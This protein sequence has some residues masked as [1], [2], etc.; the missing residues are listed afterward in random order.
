MAKNVTVTLGTPIPGHKGPIDKVVIREPRAGDYFELGEPVIY[1]QSREGRLIGAE[2]TETVKAYLDRLIV[3]PKD[4]LVLG[5]MDLA[6]SMKVKAAMMD[7]FIN[8][9]LKSFG[10]DAISSS[11]TSESSTPGAV[12]I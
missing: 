8:A 11:S 12:A 1:T 3:E 9:R 7:F 2:H 5:Q 4:Q 10:I 6:D